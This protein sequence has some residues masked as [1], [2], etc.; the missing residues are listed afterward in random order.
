MVDWFKKLNFSAVA[1]NLVVALAFLLPLFFLPIT[2]DLFEMNK[3]F[4]FFAV[5]GIL[6][7]LAAVQIVIRREVRLTRTPWT[8]PI[9]LFGLATLATLLV[10]SPNKV[11]ALLGNGGMY[12]AFALFFLAATTLIERSFTKKLIAG[13][14][15]SGFVVTITTLFDRFGMSLTD[16]L[17]NS[18]GLSIPQGTKLFL[19]GSPLFSVFFLGIVGTMLVIRFLQTKGNKQSFMSVVFAAICLI[20]I[21][22][23]GEALLPGRPTHPQFLSFLNSWSIATDVL[24]T[25]LNAV[26]GVGTD[27]YANAFSIFRPLRLNQTPTW[28]IRYNNARNSLLELL[29]T[30]GVLS[31]ALW[32]LIFLIT[33]RLVKTAKDEHFA[34]GI[35]TLLIELILLFFPPNI[36]LISLFSIFLVAWSASLKER[37]VRVTEST[38]SLFA[39]VDLASTPTLNGVQKSQKI[40]AQIFGLLLVLTILA[41]FY[42]LARVYGA[43]LWFSRSVNA[44]TK[45]N[46]K[47]TYD[48]AIKAV[49]SNPFMENYHRAFAITNL[50]LAQGLSQK[51]DLTDVEKQNVIALIQQAIQQAKVAT[52]LDSLNTANWDTLANVYQALI[53]A[54]QDAD[55]WTV[56]A[57]VEQIKTD[58]GSPQVRFSLGSIYRQIGNDEMALQLFQQATQLKPDYA[59]AYFNMAD[60]YKKK[61]DKVNELAMLQITLSLIT[62]EQSGYQNVKSRIDELQGEAKAKTQTAPKPSPSPSPTV[63]KVTLPSESGPS[64][65]DTTI[66]EVPQP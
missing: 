46:A 3:R 37:R 17:N 32:L 61:G 64:V 33:L 60:I 2:T 25:P 6:L 7:I 39:S 36:L 44:A 28:F 12:I 51:K 40:V 56:A 57:Y 22:V 41:G 66:P 34:L 30:Q 11:M 43:E 15:F 38:F 31:M 50:S 21:L 48:F 52:T 13:L 24:K 65:P 49:I 23:N 19:T 20:G 29:A 47:D 62:A 14:A 55:Q 53:G 4:L 1:S 16:I 10:V 58:P 35:G 63:S 9:F 8:T 26:L 42:G 59:N 18:F 45:G 27:S 54:V 5:T